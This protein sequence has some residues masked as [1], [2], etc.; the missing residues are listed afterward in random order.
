MNKIVNEEAL[1]KMAELQK[2][3]IDKNKLPDKG[4]EG[5]ILTK[6]EDGV[7]WSSPVV[8]WNALENEKGY[9]KNKPFDDLEVVEFVNW[10]GTSIVSDG[11]RP[12]TFDLLRTDF[13]EEQEYKIYITADRFDDVQEIDC[14][15]SNEYLSPKIITFGGDGWYGFSAR[16]DRDWNLLV[17]SDFPSNYPEEFDISSIRLIGPGLSK[18]NPNKVDLHEYA[19]TDDITKTLTITY[20][21]KTVTYNGT[22]EKTITIDIPDVSSNDLFKAGTGTKSI[23]AINNANSETGQN[24][25]EG[26][27]AF[28]IGRNTQAIGNNSF[29][30]G[31]NTKAEGPA[32]HTE[33][34]E[35]TAIGQRAHAEGHSTI[36]SGY[37]SHAEGRST[38]A[39]GSNSHA[40]GYVTKATGG[41]SHAE[42]DGSIA[43]GTVSHAEGMSTTASGEQSHAEGLSTRAGGAQSHAEGNETKAIGH[44]AHAEGTN[45][46]A[47]RRASHA[48]GYY[49]EANGL[50]S[51]AEGWQTIAEG[52]SSHSEG[53]YSQAIGHYSHAEGAN[54]RAYNEG[55]HA[56]GMHNISTKKESSDWGDPENTLFSIGNGIKG[57]GAAGSDNVHRHNAFE[58]KQDGTILIP[59]TNSPEVFYNK[60]ML[61]LQ[62]KLQ[63]LD[64]L[65]E[66]PTNGYEYVDMGE[67]GIWATCNVGANSPEEF[68]LYFAWG[69]TEGYF[70]AESGK[71]F[72]DDDYKFYN[73]SQQKFTRYNDDPSFG[74]IDYATTLIPMDDAVV[75]NM[76]GNWRMPT[77]NEFNKL[78]EVC[79]IDQ[80]DYND[81]GINGLLFTLLSDTSK[82]LFFPYAGSCVQGNL[83]YNN[84]EGMYWSSSLCSTYNG[85]SFYCTSGSIIENDSTRFYGFS[86][87]GF[88]PSLNNKKEKYLSKIEASEIYA[89]K[90]YVDEKLSG[91]ESVNADWN[92]DWNAQE[93]ESGYIKNKPFER[94]ITDL[95]LIS[96]YTLI[97]DESN[98]PSMSGADIFTTELSVDEF[99][100]ISSKVDDIPHLKIV[101]NNKEYYPQYMIKN[102]GNTISFDFVNEQYIIA[103][104]AYNSRRQQ[105]LFTIVDETLFPSTD[106]LNFELYSY[107]KEVINKL[108]EVFYNRGGDWNA[109]KEESGYIENK[110]FEEISN[111]YIF[112][113]VETD[114][115]VSTSTGTSGADIFINSDQKELLVKGKNYILT[116]EYSSNQSK[117]YLFEY[118]S[119]YI[120]IPGYGEL[121]IE[122]DYITLV[123]YGASNQAIISLMLDDTI[124]KK[125]DPKYLPESII[126]NDGIVNTLFVYKI[127][128]KLSYFEEYSKL[129]IIDDYPEGDSW[130]TLGNDITNSLVYFAGGD[131]FQLITV[132]QPEY[133][134]K[135]VRNWKGKEQYCKEGTNQI[136]DNIIIRELDLSTEYPGI[137]QISN[138]F[139]GNILM[140]KYDYVRSHTDNFPYLCIL[141]Q[142]INDSNYIPESTYMDSI[143]YYTVRYPIGGVE[144][145][146]L[147][148]EK[149]N[150]LPFVY[151]GD[152]S[153]SN[154]TFP[155]WGEM[156]DWPTYYVKYDYPNGINPENFTGKTYQ[157]Y[158]NE[159]HN[160]PN[161]ILFNLSDYGLK[162]VISANKEIVE[163]H[164]FVSLDEIKNRTCPLEIDSCYYP[165]QAKILYCKELNTFFTYFNE[166]W[167]EEKYSYP[168]PWTVVEPKINYDNPALLSLIYDE[169]NT[170]EDKVIPFYLV[171]P[172]YDAIYLDVNTGTMYEY[173]LDEEQSDENKRTG[174]RK[175]IISANIPTQ[176]GETTGS[177]QTEYTQANGDY[178]VAYGIQTK[179][180]GTG[181]HAEGI[182]T[183]AGNSGNNS[184][185]SGA[186]SEGI[187]T[188]ALSMGS[189]AEGQNT[190]ASGQNGSTG[191]SHAEGQNTRAYSPA[192]HSEGIGTVAG[193]E[194]LPSQNSAAHAEGI[195]TSA[196]AEASHAE[197]YSSTAEGVY[198][199]AEGNQSK[200]EGYSSHAEG[201][202]TIAKG[203]C[204]HT[205]GMVTQANS[206]SAHA[207]GNFTQ[208]NGMSSHA[209]GEHTIT[210]NFAEHASGKYNVSN[211][212]TLFSIGNGKSDTER[213]NAFEVK[214]NGDVYIQKEGADVKLQN[215]FPVVLLQTQYDSLEQKDPNTIYFIVEAL[216]V[217]DQL[218]EEL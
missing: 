45:T 107:Q 1:G 65:Y 190:I 27:N 79:Q 172:R 162:R 154:Y 50:V 77:K 58:V 35:T 73:K 148:Q 15:Y 137:P 38:E 178:S 215:A 143:T 185:T 14:I 4:S 30:S 22:E 164:G 33:G 82:Q 43:E 68:G 49:S 9:I 28:A 99:E 95:E 6:T 84:F 170:E 40:E 149:F 16:I 122:G 112:K 123:D 34:E 209:E 12:F 177:I 64:V 113:D 89:T 135:L 131:C 41:H 184:G 53:Q 24:K 44:A 104:L 61:N 203:Y 105:I 117:Q 114:F 198:S 169:L 106:T 191:S 171:P 116:V 110:P 155:C 158:A 150:L 128:D 76:G 160:D 168:A 8:D 204:S 75:Q 156:P 197:G 115:L 193:K 78:I 98:D 86:V 124:I 91:E 21:N 214:D 25:A 83:E 63:E 130:F 13:V 205:E 48:E 66:D 29:A 207:E 36:A 210:N 20:D 167:G 39:S 208:A 153:I 121:S 23:V 166:E 18:L 136:K 94:I 101:V 119:D 51:H 176:S 173:F 72:S 87:R 3:Y 139:N 5:D 2:E 26:N 133:E 152:S 100:K 69:E 93:G 37:Q 188:Q 217:S 11:G 96:K 71:D 187:G 32:S 142:Q 216:Q 70:D 181:S 46:I 161:F 194:N 151:P 92:A 85:F 80:I 211:E 195:N 17:I 212:D 189:H 145:N 202:Q 108:D 42:G 157:I 174:L 125:I 192:S 218:L 111:V 146:A 159:T 19:K 182:Q 55:E 141:T 180:Y 147:N 90:E 10:E 144:S 103:A 74:I 52:T 126:K 47:Y 163:F 134:Q 88:M 132:S 118:T 56:S 179:A 127:V 62:D 109:Q 102:L 175:H 201:M 81:S 57:G 7:E 59:N 97:R 54:T 67:A 165:E 60:P 140:S 206:T 196:L 186:H 138:T 199:H 31:L 183:I 120:V 129:E 200:A 213:N